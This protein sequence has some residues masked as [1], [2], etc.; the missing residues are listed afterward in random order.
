MSKKPI[1]DIVYLNGYDRDIKLRYPEPVKLK[2]SGY[3]WLANV[4]RGYPGACIEVSLDQ[5]GHS[6]YP[7]VYRNYRQGKRNYQALFVH[8]D[9]W[10]VYEWMAR[11][12]HLRKKYW[13][14]I[15]EARKLERKMQQECAKEL[16]GLFL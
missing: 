4:P 12:K 5:Y 16:E 3:G 9:K 7:K 8:E 6:S 14:K 1:P 13:P 15:R 11:A 2:W 10:A